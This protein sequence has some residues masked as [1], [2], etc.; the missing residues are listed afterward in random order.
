MADLTILHHPACSTSRHALD[1]AAAA[2]V[3]VDV[4]QY[5]KQPLSRAE[6]LELIGRLEDSPA[7]LVRKDGFFKGLELDPAAYETP[8]AVA[9]LL[10]EHP[11]L[12]QRP[13]LVR[14]DR[15]II[16][17]PKD[18]VAAFLAGR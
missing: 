18:R 2:G 14:G 5:L 12:M 16:G 10:V 17:R 7:D 9:D 15:A 11:R 4:V 3:D 1:E 8:E 6:L 13:V